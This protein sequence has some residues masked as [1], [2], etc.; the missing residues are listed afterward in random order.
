LHTPE[1]F[2]E[3]VW[4]KYSH[5]KMEPKL[6]YLLLNHFHF[7]QIADGSY[8]ND[9]F[10]KGNIKQCIALRRKF[11]AE[12]NL[13]DIKR[14]RVVVDGVI[15]SLL[16]FNLIHRKHTLAKLSE[17]R[18][19]TDDIR[20]EESNEDIIIG[21]SN[22]AWT[23]PKKRKKISESEP[24]ISESKPARYVQTIQRQ[25][26][27]S[28]SRKFPRE[29][30]NLLEDSEEVGYTDFI[31]WL[32]SGDSFAITNVVL[33]SN[34]ILAM[35]CVRKSCKTFS[36]FEGSLIC[37]G[38]EKIVCNDTEGSYRYRHPYFVRGQV[39]ILDL[40]KPVQNYSYVTKSARKKF[41]N[42]NTITSVTDTSS[43]NERVGF[44]TTSEALLRL[45]ETED[46]DLPSTGA[47]AHVLV[48]TIN[49]NKDEED[50]NHAPVAVITTTFPIP[51]LPPPLHNPA[52]AFG[53]I[54]IGCAH[55][56]DSGI[57]SVASASYT[58]DIKCANAFSNI[59]NKLNDNNCN[60]NNV[61]DVLVNANTTTNNTAL[62]VRMSDDQPTQKKRKSISL[63]SL[64]PT[65]KE[66]ERKGPPKKCF[67]DISEMVLA[68]GMRLS[69][70]N[71]P[72]HLNSLHCF[73]RSTLLEVFVLKPGSFSSSKQH[74]VVGIRCTQCGTISKKERGKEKMAVFFPK[75]VRDLYRGVW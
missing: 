2:E 62:V 9:V 69:H 66:S 4:P 24:I 19:A 51:L 47:T 15:D 43:T 73:V 12:V 11:A 59:N 74:N 64:D 21:E 50:N 32:P 17:R 48:T 57:A 13:M 34:S 44:S 67:R 56:N 31:H 23:K 70:P 1:K 14:I 33:F 28:R 61:S 18:K 55:T 46:L 26:N 36:S 39:K 72:K 54:G 5:D 6:F 49:T 71:D 45:P 35:R 60:N 37:F 58:D 68:Q 75:S 53:T 22:G 16:P 25:Y 65:S 40:V 52:R 3:K 27:V 63:S 7:T 20:T 29:L 10:C 8:Y 41:N 38:F 30:H 42:A